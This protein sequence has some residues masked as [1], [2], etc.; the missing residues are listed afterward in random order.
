VARQVAPP[1]CIELVGKDQQLESQFSTAIANKRCASLVGLALLDCPI[2]IDDQRAQQGRRVV[3]T[4][5][6]FEGDVRSDL[7]HRLKQPEK[8]A[9]L[10][11][12]AHDHLVEAWLSG[13]D[14]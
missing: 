8:N 13:Q 9:T 11:T 12:P 1:G 4:T 3:G 6:G 7:I 5:C 10:V 2:G 14:A